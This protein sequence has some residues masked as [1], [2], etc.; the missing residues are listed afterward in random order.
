M[1]QIVRLHV[2]PALIAVLWT[3]APAWGEPRGAGDIQLATASL[4]AVKPGLTVT[5]A[6]IRRWTSATEL[7][8]EQLK[9]FGFQIGTVDEAKLKEFLE[10]SEDRQARRF[11]DYYDSYVQGMPSSQ[12][13]LN[14]RTDKF[15]KMLGNAY[16]WKELSIPAFVQDAVELGQ[17][18]EEKHNQLVEA[19]KIAD[20]EAESAEVTRARLQAIRIFD[21]VRR[22]GVKRARGYKLLAEAVKND[23]EGRDFRQSIALMF[24]VGSAQRQP[25]IAP[26]TIANLQCADGPQGEIVFV[27][28]R[29]DC[30]DRGVCNVD[31][32][33]SVQ[34]NARYK[35]VFTALEGNEGRKYLDGCKFKTTMLINGVEIERTTSGRFIAH[36]PSIQP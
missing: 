29:K 15:G 32:I 12:G 4:Y 6:T 14:S 25:T 9:M 36:N 20:Q 17:L 22:S 11:V 21:D 3:G 23:W 30:N 8:E 10:A 24:E 19:L 13:G 33:A 28:R 2:L 1:K 5:E 16:V 26:L 27:Q 7:S 18:D 31:A 35:A 34:D